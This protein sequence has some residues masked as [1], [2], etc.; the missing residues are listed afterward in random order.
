MQ[1]RSAALLRDVVTAA[2]RIQGFVADRCW[3]DYDGDV[4]FPETSTTPPAASSS[5]R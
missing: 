1:P 3:Q 5:R 2:K 4:L